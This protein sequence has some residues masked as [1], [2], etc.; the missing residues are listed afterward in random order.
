MT[1]T[2]LACPECDRAGV[3]PFGRSY[4]ARVNHRYQCRR[5]GWTGDEPVEREP[6]S[7]TRPPSGTVARR[8]AELDP[9]AI[10][11]EQDE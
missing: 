8:L 10:G 7:T 5:C 9:D 4:N 2:L 11:G 3:R 6:R 1:D